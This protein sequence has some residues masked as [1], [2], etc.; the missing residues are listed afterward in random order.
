[1]FIGKA[2]ICFSIV[3]I[4]NFLKF[5]NLTRL[6]IHLKQLCPNVLVSALAVKISD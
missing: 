2:A 5:L 1:M 6:N 3:F 4:S